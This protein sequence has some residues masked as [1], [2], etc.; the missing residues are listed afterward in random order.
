M[1][2][3]TSFMSNVIGQVAD[4]RT[5]KHKPAQF[6]SLTWSEELYMVEC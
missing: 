4:R 5:D 3:E 1:T 2:T 6:Q